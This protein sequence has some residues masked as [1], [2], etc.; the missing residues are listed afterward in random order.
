MLHDGGY[1]ES[2]RNG[3]YDGEYGHNGKQCAICQCRGFI[4]D[5]VFREAVDTE[6]NGFNDVI[7]RK[8]GSGHFVL[9]DAPDI[10][11]DEFPYIG[12]FFLHGIHL[13]L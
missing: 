10:I 12:Y 8:F 6:V 13:E 2:P 4:D 3:E 9:R 5:T 7:N 1:A 11:S